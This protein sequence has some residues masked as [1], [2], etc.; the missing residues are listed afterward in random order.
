MSIQAIVKKQDKNAIGVFEAKTTLS[1]LLERVA[2][3]ET[4]VITRH[5]VPVARLLPFDAFD[6]HSAHAAVQGLLQ[7]NTSWRLPP[8]KTIKDLL[9]E[10]R[11]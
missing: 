11:K 3:G 5:G 8:G 6:P 2:R 9:R 10:G 1:K 7:L 4:I